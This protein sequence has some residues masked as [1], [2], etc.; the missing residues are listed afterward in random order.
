M[1]TKPLRWLVHFE[2]CKFL[3]T[4]LCGLYYINVGVSVYCTKFEGAID[5]RIISIK[6]DGLKTSLSSKTFR[7]G[8][9]SDIKTKWLPLPKTDWFSKRYTNIM[10]TAQLCD[11]YGRLEIKSAELATCFVDIS[12]N[13]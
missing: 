11:S 9:C 2:E 8:R 1:A 10:G 13:S 7:D 3:A 6:L 5:P 12:T 4:Q